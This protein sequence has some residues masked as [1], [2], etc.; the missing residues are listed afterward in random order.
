MHCSTPTC[1]VWCWCGKLLAT[2]ASTDY[3]CFR[4]KYYAFFGKLLWPSKGIAYESNIYQTFHPSR[5][6]YVFKLLLFTWWH[7]P[8]YPSW[9]ESGLLMRSTYKMTQVGSTIVHCCWNVFIKAHS[10]P[11]LTIAIR[12][13]W[14]WSSPGNLELVST[15]SPSAQQCDALPIRPW[16]T[17]CPKLAWKR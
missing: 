11:L 5:Q 6:I 13:W 4:R 2:K 9:H 17:Q 12:G 1:P 10:P 14:G 15:Q 16:T 7:T 3:K 8:S